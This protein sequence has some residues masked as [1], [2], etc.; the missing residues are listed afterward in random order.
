MPSDE[1]RETIARFHR[2][3]YDEAERGGTWK[4]TY[5]QGVPAHKCPLDMW[6]YQEMIHEIRPDVIVETGTYQ[7]GSALYLASVCDVV[8]HGEVISI[9][10][11]P[12]PGL[13]QHER[14]MYLL[15]S[16]TADEIVEKVR[17]RVA[18]G[19]A[20]VV[21]DSDHSAEHV[22][23][24][25]RAYSPLVTVGSYLIVEDTNV[26]GNPILPGWG[27]GPRE[28]VEEFLEGNDGFVVDESREKFFMTFNPGG[29]LKRVR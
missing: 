7:G 29:Y 15:G 6:V 25:L 12:Q 26:N 24:E 10:I 28:A 19:S 23:N 17:S 1:Q 2:L 9:D 22:G 20:M 3:Y 13:P 27:P 11:D 8:G 5:W 16:S 21:L 4:N 14:V 18:G